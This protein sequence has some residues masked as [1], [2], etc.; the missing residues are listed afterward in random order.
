MLARMLLNYYRL[1]ESLFFDHWKAHTNVLHKIY[2]V[3][4]PNDLFWNGCS[5]FS[6][7]FELKL[8]IKFFKSARESTSKNTYLLYVN[9]VD[10]FD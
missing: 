7:I 8:F 5:D 6:K 4:S 2:Y 10:L 9:I 1:K 3:Y